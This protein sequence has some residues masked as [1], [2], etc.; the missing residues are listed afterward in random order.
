MHVTVIP[1][2]STGRPAFP[3]RLT[4]AP[5]LSI[6]DG[7]GYGLG[8]FPCVIEPEQRAYLKGARI[9]CRDP[10]WFGV[11]WEAPKD[12][13]VLYVAGWHAW[14]SNV[15]Q[16][17][18]YC[19]TSIG[20]WEER[21]WTGRHTGIAIQTDTNQ[22]LRAVF[23]DGVSFPDHANNGAVLVIPMRDAVNITL[24][25]SRPNTSYSLSLWS[26]VATTPADGDPFAWTKQW[27]QIDGSGATSGTIDVDVSGSGIGA[28]LLN[29]VRHG[30]FTASKSSY[31]TFSNVKVRCEGGGMD[32]T[33]YNVVTHALSLL[34][35]E[36]LPAGA[37]YLRGIAA[38][39]GEMDNLV[40]PAKT[41]VA[42]VIAEVCARQNYAFGWYAGRV[43]GVKQALPFFYP[44]STTPD[45]VLDMSRVEGE[46][47][48]T[49]DYETMA[50]TV[51]VTYR[52]PSGV[53]RYE[54]VTDSDAAHY[55]V[56]SGL[57]KDEVLD[58]GDATSAAAILRGQ[59]YLLDAGRDRV[60]GST[61]ADTLRAKTMVPA[62]FDSLRCGQTV[63]LMNVGGRAYLDAVVKSAE[64]EDSLTLDVDSNAYRL[65]E[66]V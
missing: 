28:L 64:L 10:D 14:A 9:V 17:L 52:D 2:S 65:S 29:V 35:D 58:I 63:R 4:D 5:K 11:A 57:S 31:C 27:E 50:R 34:D 30:A 12:D 48:S 15:R 19:H 45:Y 49:D 6:F 26:G 59:A 22:Y 56:R 44:P 39:A 51:V 33:A 18:W 54:R 38:P 25:W 40:F 46:R 3:L 13:G 8:E 53:E 47:L 43:G 32:A 37:E 20:E 41:T 66:V 36:A 21:T 24:A 60:S 23:G 61:P 7:S 62:R 1:P 42:E 16:Q 55:L